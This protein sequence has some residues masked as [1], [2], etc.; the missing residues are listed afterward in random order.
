MEEIN[1]EREKI[2][3]EQKNQDKK[4]KSENLIKIYVTLK[5]EYHHPPTKSMLYSN[6]LVDNVT[7]EIIEKYY[8]NYDNF[9]NWW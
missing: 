2:K 7:K 3:L 4:V 1:R 9:V 6:P 5:E 8:G